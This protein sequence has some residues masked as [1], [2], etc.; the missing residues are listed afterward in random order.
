MI[1]FTNIHL[2][3]SKRSRN[4]LRWLTWSNWWQ[5]YPYGDDQAV[6]G[7]KMIWNEIFP[8][9]VFYTFSKMIVFILFGHFLEPSLLPWLI[10]AFHWYEIQ[11]PSLEMHSSTTKRYI[12]LKSCMPSVVNE[13]FIL[14][15]IKVFVDNKLGILHMYYQMQ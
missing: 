13:E 6:P 3:C 4:I 7:I 15:T 1:D 14:K 2:E 12:Q 10:L 5:W 11:L 9:N 8:H